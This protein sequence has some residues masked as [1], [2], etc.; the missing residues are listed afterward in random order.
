MTDNTSRHEADRVTDLELGD[1]IVATLRAQ[2][3]TVA[4]QTVAAVTVE[5]PGYAG[6]LSGTR[7]EDIEKA[8]RIAL[9]AFLRLAV[10]SKHSDPSAPLAPALDAAYDLGRGEARNGRAMDALLSAY[11]V[12]ARV[13]WRELS[14]TAVTAGLPAATMAKF[15]ELL[16]AYIDELS[17][18][19]V[20]GHADELATAG[21]VRERYLE[22]LA[23]NL[24]AGQPD[25]ILVSSAERA[26]WPPPQTLTAVLLPEAQTRAVVSRIDQR[27]LQLVADLP[28]IEATEAVALLLVPDADG[29]N[30]PQLL[31]I[32][33]GRH[34]VVGPAR[35]WM[36]VH[37][38]YR[39]ALR[40][41]GLTVADKL[42]VLDTDAHL[43]E[44]VLGADA[45]ALQDLRRQMLAPM[46][47]L[48]AATADRLTETLRSWL[49]HQ[50]GRDRVAADLFIH[51]QTVRYR[52]AQLRELYGDRLNDPRTILE[53]TVA[54]AI[55]APATTPPPSTPR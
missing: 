11:R 32:L 45:E 23:Q 20:T 10:R 25:E 22:R 8:V 42:D 44:L 24:L 43:A 2:L 15:A 55:P 31:R 37:S 48:P 34:A 27:T 47:A 26:N 16:F 7:G 33:E 29:T 41:R 39:R 35:A 12:G 6:P 14:A 30:R 3:P 28:G 5:V 36:R 38:S 49:L 54:L 50:G 9:G 1:D 51:A 46:A 4:E 17:A 52:M 13:A 19:S 53:L 18:A 40:G 21:R